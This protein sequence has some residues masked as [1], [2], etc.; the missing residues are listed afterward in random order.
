M[1]QRDRWGDFSGPVDADS[2]TTV[3]KLW[4][5]AGFNRK[6][7]S[8]QA[9]AIADLRIEIAAAVARQD[10]Q[11]GHIEKVTGAHVLL[12]EAIKDLGVTVAALKAFVEEQSAEAINRH[13][14]SV[15]TQLALTEL[16][17]KMQLRTMSSTEH[18]AAADS[19][20]KAEVAKVSLMTRGFL[21]LSSLFVLSFGALAAIVAPMIASGIGWMFKRLLSDQ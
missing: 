21:I 10:E 5:E 8:K 19:A 4:A 18:I 9:Q 1:E 14:E 3:Q 12:A 2:K 7:V 13:K 11:I 15:A 20:R 17:N 16:I 6:L